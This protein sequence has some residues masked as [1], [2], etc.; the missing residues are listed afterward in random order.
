MIIKLDYTR[1][2][3][4]KNET[5]EEKKN[6]KI[7]TYFWRFFRL[8]KLI[9]HKSWPQTRI[10]RRIE[11]LEESGVNTPR[12][13]SQ[14]VCRQPQN[15]EFIKG[16]GGRRHLPSSFSLETKENFSEKREI[17]IFIGRSDDKFSYYVD[18]RPTEFTFPRETTRKR[19]REYVCPRV[20]KPAP[21]TRPQNHLNSAL[22]RI[23]I[24]RRKNSTT[25][26]L[27]INIF[28]PSLP[29]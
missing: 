25:K 8:D 21:F 2:F 5:K 6:W 19:S 15:A 16:R 7:Y 3:Y 14:N 9:E 13:R 29:L 26:I 18:N 11:N 4:K 12:R 17:W 24:S 1:F 22:H 27:F 20:F 28:H 23:E 10:I